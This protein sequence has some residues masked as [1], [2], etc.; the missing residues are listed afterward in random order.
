MVAPV[1]GHGRGPVKS[2]HVAHVRRDVRFRHLGTGARRDRQVAVAAA[3]V[4]N[5]GRED[6]SLRR[7]AA[8]WEISERSSAAA[9]ALLLLLLLFRVFQGRQQPRA[10]AMMDSP[11]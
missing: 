2:S 3:V 1:A 7:R 8:R 5:G 4:V 6:R 10:S 11:I 9:D